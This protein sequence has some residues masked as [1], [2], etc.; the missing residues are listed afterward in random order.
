MSEDVIHKMIMMV[1]EGQE[2]CAPDFAQHLVHR[3]RNIHVPINTQGIEATT[4]VDCGKT[5]NFIDRSFTKTRGLKPASLQTSMICR[6]GEGVTQMT[7]T[8]HSEAIV[9][10]KQVPLTIFVMNGKSS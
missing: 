1:D 4:L 2:M 3:E 10:Y 5:D 8:F 9:A 7:H 6:L